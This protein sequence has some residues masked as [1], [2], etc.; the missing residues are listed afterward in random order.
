VLVAG[1]LGGWL[2]VAPDEEL[3]VRGNAALATMA[4]VL[5]AAGL[6]VRVAL[7][8]P[9]AIA[10]LV[11]AYLAL[12]GFELDS[13]DSRAPLV[14]AALLAVAEL[15]YWSLELR[16]AVADE[17]GTY[18]RRAALLA[19]QLAGVTTVGVV[20]LAVVEGIETG[21]VAIQVLGVLAAVGALALLALAAR[22][23]PT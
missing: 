17:P 2:S 21:G 11:A 7:A 9:L 14:A 16:E 19:V 15:G 12:L 8:I 3:L 1:S 13:L 23:K 18:L 20:L 22:S 4:A 6:L 10:L 5:L